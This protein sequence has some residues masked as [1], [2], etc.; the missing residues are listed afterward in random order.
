MFYQLVLLTE[1]LED[2]VGL[3]D[4]LFHPGAH[5][6][7]HRA[8]VLQD[9]LGGLRLAG[10]ALSG[11][12][13]GLVLVTRLQGRVRGLCQRECVRLQQT[14]LLSVVLEHVLLRTVETLISK[15][16]M[17]NIASSLL[18]TIASEGSANL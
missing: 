18:L 4:L 7:G 8:Q 10:A 17:Y 13:A 9:E 2:S 14:Q 6:A 12:H 16:F 11:D 15:K 3:Q 1:S 5:V